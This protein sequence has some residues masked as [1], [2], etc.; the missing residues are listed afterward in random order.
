MVLN[1]RGWQ[2]LFLLEGFP[3]V[4]LGG[5]GLVL[6]GR[7]PQ[8]ARWLTKED[9]QCLQEMLESDRLQLAKQ[10]DYGALPQSAMWR[11]IFTPWC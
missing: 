3:S 2:W 1:M 6:S 9:K 5:G 8:K 11:E 4:L 7:Y 10:A